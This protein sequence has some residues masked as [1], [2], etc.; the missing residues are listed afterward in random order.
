MLEEGGPVSAQ[1]SVGADAA[2]ANAAS[3][4]NAWLVLGGALVFFMHSGFALLEVGSVSQ[5]NVQ[6][7]LFKNAVSPTFAALLFWMFGYTF[8]FGGNGEG[9]FIGTRVRTN[10]TARASSTWPRLHTCQIVIVRACAHRMAGFLRQA[11]CS[12]PLAQGC[13]VRNS[14][15]R[16]FCVPRCSLTSVLCGLQTIRK[17]TPP[18]FSSGR[19]LPLLRPSCQGP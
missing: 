16:S 10:C 13:L 5:K 12:S 18:G 8:A 1:C 3:M 14:A 17:S 11:T 2:A 6:N 7:I 15:R 19:L 9:G 4:D